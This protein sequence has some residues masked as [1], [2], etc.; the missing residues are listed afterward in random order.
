LNIVIR[1][2]CRKCINDLILVTI[3]LLLCSALW[4]KLRSLCGYIRYNYK[5]SCSIWFSG[6]SDDLFLVT[7]AY[8]YIF[9]NYWYGTRFCHE[10][11]CYK[12]D[13][14]DRVE[15][16]VLFAWSHPY[17]CHDWWHYATCYRYVDGFYSYIFI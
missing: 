3:L 6:R 14:D 8:S 2:P 4:C 13:N 11:Y 17:I 5:G 7:S 10:L 1:Y 15:T 9:R 16:C 12:G